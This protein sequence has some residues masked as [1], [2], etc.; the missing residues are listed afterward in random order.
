MV[1][2]VIGCGREVY[3][4]IRLRC[5]FQGSSLGLGGRG[6]DLQ[7]RT[8]SA[9]QDAEN[10]SVI[11]TTTYVSCFSGT[12]ISTTVSISSSRTRRVYHAVIDAKAK[13]EVKVAG[14]SDIEVHLCTFAALSTRSISVLMGVI[15]NMIQGQPTNAVN[16]PIMYRKISMCTVRRTKDREETM[17]NIKGRTKQTP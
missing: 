3:R 5:S 4:L 14:K 8:R 1:R 15:L 13:T 7:R 17:P 9:I 6:N 16:L 2:R 12:N 10:R 11:Y